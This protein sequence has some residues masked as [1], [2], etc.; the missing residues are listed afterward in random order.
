MRAVKFRGKALDCG[1][2]VYGDLLQFILD[3]KPVKTGFAILPFEYTR[4][5]GTTYENE[6]ININYDTIGQF[7][8]RY[9]KNGIEIYEGD[10]IKVDGE[11]PIAFIMYDCKNASFDLQWCGKEKD[12][13][14]MC[15]LSCYPNWIEVIGNIYDNPELLATHQ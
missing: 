11:H 15:Y 10:I 12:D 3:G 8:G 9:D 4:I 7:T 2:F 5:N 13:I 14:C 6:P 1:K